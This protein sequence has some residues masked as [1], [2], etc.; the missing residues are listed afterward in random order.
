MTT[1]KYII[2]YEVKSKGFKFN[3]LSYDPRIVESRETN[4]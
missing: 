4:F 2:S 3:C 1:G